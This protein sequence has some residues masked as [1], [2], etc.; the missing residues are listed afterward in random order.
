MIVLSPLARSVTMK[1]FFFM[2][3]LSVKKSVL[4]MENSVDRIEKGAK[5]NS[6]FKEK[7]EV[8]LLG[9]YLWRTK[10]LVIARK[11]KKRQSYC[12]Q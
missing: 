12:Y 9:R 8:I 3:I 1:T 2:Q 7:S 11:G 5:I 10:P 4:N 6:R